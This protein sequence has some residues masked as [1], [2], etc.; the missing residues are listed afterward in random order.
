[1]WLP[2]HQVHLSLR[3]HYPGRA[4]AVAKKAAEWDKQHQIWLRL[5]VG[6]CTSSYGMGLGQ[7]FPELKQW[8]DWVKGFALSMAGRFGRVA[9]AGGGGERRLGR[10][11]RS[12]SQRPPQT[13]QMEEGE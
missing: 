8:S 4:A 10:R 6:M 1:M 2:S 9:G 11:W 12:W 3:L 5:E 13:P 7:Q